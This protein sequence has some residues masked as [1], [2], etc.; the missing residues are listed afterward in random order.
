MNSLRDD[1]YIALQQPVQGYLCSSLAVFL[2]YLGEGRVGS[3][4]T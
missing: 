3:G 4:S 2:A 1:D